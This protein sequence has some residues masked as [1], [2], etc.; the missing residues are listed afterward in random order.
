MSIGD[1]SPE[2]GGVVTPSRF[3]KQ[4]QVRAT[5]FSVL[6]R[7]S[8]TGTPGITHLQNDTGCHVLESRDDAGQL[9]AVFSLLDDGELLLMTD[10]ACRRQGLATALLAEADRLGL[11][12]NFQKQLYTRAGWAVVQSFRRRRE[13][14]IAR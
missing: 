1:D 5:W 9:R 2:S 8:W 7:S 10:P 11:A 14:A 3:L 6:L 13:E 12:V 4:S